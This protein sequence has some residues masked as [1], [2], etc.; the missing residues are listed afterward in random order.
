MAARL[1]HGGHLKPILAAAMQGGSPAVPEY[2]QG[3]VPVLG[4]EE[5]D[6]F[7]VSNTIYSPAMRTRSAAGAIALMCR[8]ISL[9]DSCP[10]YHAE[11]GQAFLAAGDLTA[12]GQALER[13]NA[14][15]QV[16][17]VPAG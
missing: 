6:R 13:A 16:D 10:Y 3:T 1:K 14:L 12:A 2:V 11:L 4:A 17:P 5:V 8:A 15:A 7:M 9:F